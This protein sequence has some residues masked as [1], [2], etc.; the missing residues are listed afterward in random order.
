MDDLIKITTKNDKFEGQRNLSHT[1]QHIKYYKT[2]PVWV[3]GKQ[4]TD[5]NKDDVTAEGIKG[6]VKFIPPTYNSPA[7]LILNNAVISDI[8]G[9]RDNYGIYANECHLVIELVGE[10]EIDLSH[11]EN[12]FNICGICSDSGNLTIIGDG[13]LLV[14]SGKTVT[15]T[16][17][18]ANGSSIGIYV[19]NGNVT[20]SDEVTIVSKGGIGQYVYGIAIGSDEDD[21][22][23]YKISICQTA[24]VDAIMMVKKD[25]SESEKGSGKGS[26]V[27]GVIY[28]ADY[29]KALREYLADML[30]KHHVDKRYLKDIIDGIMKLESN[31]PNGRK[32]RK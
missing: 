19:R 21:T 2:Y 15:S 10:N 24:Y 28:P 5:G 17:D 27:G 26:I 29:E 16:P 31:I 25:G 3:A 32:T 20:I 8:Y 23:K 12:E 14:K 6:S 11:K 1:G 7:K 4:I 9:T 18:D 30:I 13:S 22:E